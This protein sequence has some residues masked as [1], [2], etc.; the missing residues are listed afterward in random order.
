MKQFIGYECDYC[1]KR[2]KRKSACLKHEQYAK[3]K[4]HPKN[5][6]ACFHC[7]FL[8]KVEGIRYVDRYDGQCEIKCQT[9]YCAHKKINLYSYK[10]DGYDTASMPTANFDQEEPERMPLQCDDLDEYRNVG[11]GERVKFKESLDFS[12]SHHMGLPF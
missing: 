5:Q 4:E 3:C 7:P 9:F 6:H 12:N 8:T 2:Y 11:F 1:G 10:L